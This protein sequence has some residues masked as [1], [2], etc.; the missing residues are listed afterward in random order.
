MPITGAVHIEAPSANEEYGRAWAFDQESG[1]RYELEIKG[2]AGGNS[3]RQRVD[4][5]TTPSLAATDEVLICTHASARTVGSIAAAL[6]K[7]QV[8]IIKDGNGSG[9]SANITFDPNG[10]ETIDGGATK[11]IV[12]ANYGTARVTSD[13]TNWWTL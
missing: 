2:A 12:A 6:C 10:S 13:G 1:L 11:A 8:F 5:T 4:A 3:Q 7:G 9:G